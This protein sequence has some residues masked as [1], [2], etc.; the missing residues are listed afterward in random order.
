MNKISRFT[1][2]KITITFLPFERKEE[3]KKFI[4]QDDNLEL[5]TRLK[6]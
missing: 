3:G 4:I 1:K 6:I 2:E 5:L